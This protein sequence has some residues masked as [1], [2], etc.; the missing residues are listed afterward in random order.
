LGAE[1]HEVRLARRQGQTGNVA[2]GYQ[3][4]ALSKRRLAGQV[5]PAVQLCAR[6][7][8]VVGVDSRVER[9]DAGHVPN[10]KIDLGDAAARH[11]GELVSSGKARANGP[12]A[13]NRPAVA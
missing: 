11:R 6:K 8:I 7:A 3:T 9:I 13:G 5:I 12:G 10:A 2:D 1:N 4:A